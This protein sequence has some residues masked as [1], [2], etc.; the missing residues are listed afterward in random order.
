LACLGLGGAGGH[1]L[2]WNEALAVSLT[3]F[4]G[5]VYFAKAFQPVDQQLR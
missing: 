3:A 1:P 5:C 2:T 4:H